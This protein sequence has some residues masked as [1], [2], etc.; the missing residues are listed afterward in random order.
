MRVSFFSLSNNTKRRGKVT[1]NK[2]T[3]EGQKCHERERTLAREHDTSAHIEK[4]ISF[5]LLFVLFCFVFPL[6]FYYSFASSLFCFSL[7]LLS[8]RAVSCVFL[9]CFVFVQRIRRFEQALASMRQTMR[10]NGWTRSQQRKFAVGR[11]AKQSGIIKTTPPAGIRPV[12]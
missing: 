7:L 2:E 11:M 10:V 12:W 1:K 8:C 6:R 5:L 4:V 9:W 3:M